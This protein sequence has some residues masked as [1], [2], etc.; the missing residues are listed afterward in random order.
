MILPDFLFWSIYVAFIICG[1]FIVQIY[2]QIGV[3]TIPLAII[4]TGVYWSMQ[5]ESEAN[6]PVT[7]SVIHPDNFD[8]AKELTSGEPL[9][10][11]LLLGGVLLLLIALIFGLKILLNRQ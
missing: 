2:K 7:A 9:Y 8:L 4:L 6:K 11:L 10:L 5:R 3:I 1:V